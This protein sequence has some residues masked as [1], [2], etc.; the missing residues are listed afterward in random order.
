MRADSITS[1]SMTRIVCGRRWSA[2]RTGW[3]RPTGS[4]ALEQTA[5]ALTDFTRRNGAKAF[6]AIVSPH[7]TNEENYRF[8]ELI[9]A[10]GAGRVAMAVR[11]GKHDDLLIKAEKAANARGVRELGLVKGDDD[12]LDELLRACEAGEIKGALYLRR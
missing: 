12:G 10:I 8:G 1:L 11:R 5:T 4:S 6:G 2:V 3:S 7:L 9:G